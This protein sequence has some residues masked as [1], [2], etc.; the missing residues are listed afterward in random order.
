M[1]ELFKKMMLPSIIS[2]IV[3]LILGVIMFIYP[4]L[5][6]EIIAKVIGFTII[7]I[8]IIG[9]LQYIKNR[10]QA[11]FKFNLIYVLTTII[12]GIVAVYRY[13]V[14]SS[15]LPVILG[16]WVCFD[17]FIKLRMAI[18]I[19]NM[20]IANYKYPLFMS[21]FSLVIGIFLVLNPFLTAT[22]IVKLVA[23]SIIIYSVID[24]IQDYTIAKYLN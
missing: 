19:K 1:E 11:S 8:G 14:I 23:A 4:E 13:K 9:I 5:T 3:F 21:I 6:L 10:E 7:G 20:G 16:I 18:G 24:I 15:I 12:L 22:F 2:S 17:S